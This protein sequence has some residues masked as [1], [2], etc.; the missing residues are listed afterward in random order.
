[1]RDVACLVLDGQLAQR[2]DQSRVAVVG[3]GVLRAGHVWFDE[4]ASQ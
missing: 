3:G 4:L 2:V 1:M